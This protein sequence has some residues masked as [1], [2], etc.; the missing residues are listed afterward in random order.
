MWQ[1]S[2]P[3]PL[4]GY[5]P[6]WGKTVL[7]MCPR[8]LNLISI[9]NIKLNAKEYQSSL[10]MNIIFFRKVFKES[11]DANWNWLDGQSLLQTQN[12]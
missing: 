8:C 5:K 6:K 9:R 4:L 7:V 1:N 11:V 10:S 3:H 12:K 2:S